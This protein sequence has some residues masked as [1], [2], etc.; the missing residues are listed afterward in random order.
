MNS[1]ENLQMQ[2]KRRKSFS[3]GG[4]TSWILIVVPLIFL[5]ITIIGYNSDLPAPDIIYTF[6]LFVVFVFVLINLYL[7]TKRIEITDKYVKVKTWFG[8]K[9]IPFNEIQNIDI[10]KKTVS[11]NG[12]ALDEEI[13]GRFLLKNGM[14]KKIA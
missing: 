10:F 8:N 1:L 13:K 6:I 14:T 11:Q 3:Y 7:L 12:I 5:F 2:L 4:T 9:Y